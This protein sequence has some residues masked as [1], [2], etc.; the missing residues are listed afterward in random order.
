V[1]NSPLPDTCINALAV[2]EKNCLWIGTENNLAVLV[3]EDWTIYTKE[4]SILPG[5]ILPIL[6]SKNRAKN[7]SSS[8]ATSLW[9]LQH[10]RRPGANRR[11]KSLELVDHQDLNPEDAEYDD[12]GNLWVSASRFYYGMDNRQPKAVCIFIIRMALKCRRFFP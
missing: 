3:G 5:S 12:D 11:K 8:E 7:G 2:D 6:N 9:R 4:N 1:H 10:R